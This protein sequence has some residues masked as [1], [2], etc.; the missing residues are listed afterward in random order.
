MGKFDQLSLINIIEILLSVIDDLVDVLRRA[1]EVR[2]TKRVRE[3][4]E[5]E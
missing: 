3:N 4:D 1:A 5:R 2:K